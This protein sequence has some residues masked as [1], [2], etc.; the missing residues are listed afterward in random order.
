MAN[1]TIPSQYT[2][3]ESNPILINKHVIIGAYSFIMPNVLICE[4]VSVGAFSFIKSSIL[5]S[6][7]YCGNPLFRLRDKSNKCM[8]LAKTYEK[9]ISNN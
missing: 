4:N 8:E 7:V 2:N 9:N 5:T 6:G 1:P 3:V